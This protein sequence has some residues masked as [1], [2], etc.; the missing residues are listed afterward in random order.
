MRAL[1]DALPPEKRG[2][3]TET[4][5]ALAAEAHH[6]IDA[7]DVILVKGSKGSRVSLVVT[8]LKKLAK[9]SGLE[10]KEGAI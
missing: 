2:R 9:T 6:L 10:H 8:A 4:A 5:E 7:G 3:H 1:Y